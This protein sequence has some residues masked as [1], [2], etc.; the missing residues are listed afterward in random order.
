MRQGDNEKMGW[1]GL[2][3]MRPR[4]YNENLIVSW[5]QENIKGFSWYSL[6]LISLDSLHPSLSWS[7][8]LM[9]SWDNES[10]MIFSWSH[11]TV[12]FSWY[13]LVSLDNCVTLCHETMRQRDHERF[14][15]GESTGIR[16]REYQENPIV[17]WD[18]ERR[19]QQ[20]ARVR[21]V[22]TIKPREYHE[23]LIISWDHDTR[24]QWEARVRS[25][26]IYETKRI[27]WKFLCFL[28][29]LY[30]ETRTFSWYSLGLMRPWDKET[31]RS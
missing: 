8:C 16:L 7:P 22:T 28:V 6:G 12:R 9:V 5:D 21:R 3:Y 1:G 23:N 15:W 31:T 20:E 25:V 11:E 29:S 19:R 4:E 26:N 30:H 17:S 27:A 2:K 10:L 14:G 24:R 13:Y 18:H